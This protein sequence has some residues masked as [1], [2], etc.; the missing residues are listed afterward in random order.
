MKT[1]AKADNIY[2]RT[3]ENIK[4]VLLHYFPT[5]TH[6]EIEE[7]AARINENRGLELNQIEFAAKNVAEHNRYISEL[8]DHKGLSL[9]NLINYGTQALYDFPNENSTKSR[10]D[11]IAILREHLLS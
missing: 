4:F 10:K 7:E 1:P 6:S 5:G 9:H 2:P 11:K 8:L 3:L